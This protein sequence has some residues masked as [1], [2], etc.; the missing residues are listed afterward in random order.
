[1]VRA[2]PARI[3][4]AIPPN[5]DKVDDLAV[6]ASHGDDN[7]SRLGEHVRDMQ[8]VCSEEFLSP[9]FNVADAETVGAL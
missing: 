8:T 7:L 1:L 3:E 5:V 2:F 4:R 9:T 6:R